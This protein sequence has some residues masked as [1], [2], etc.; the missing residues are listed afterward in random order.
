MEI[1]IE[2]RRKENFYENQTGQK[3]ALLDLFAHDDLL[4]AIIVGATP[5]N[6]IGIAIQR[7]VGRRNADFGHYYFGRFPD[8]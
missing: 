8:S 2:S 3:L 6:R 7:V 4:R 1:F 5:C